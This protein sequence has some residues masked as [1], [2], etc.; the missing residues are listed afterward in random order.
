[1][2]L[3]EPKEFTLVPA[4]TM[5]ADEVRTECITD[6]GNRVEATLLYI[7]T[8]TGKN[9][10]VIITLWDGEDY[11]NIGQWTDTDAQNRIIELIG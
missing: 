5:V 11:I 1:M 2:K 6:Y 9:Q 7:E 8:S 10:E 3:N 4:V